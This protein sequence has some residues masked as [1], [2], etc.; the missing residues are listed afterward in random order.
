MGVRELTNGSYHCFENDKEVE[1]WLESGASSSTS[2]LGDNT[3]PG[4]FAY[5]GQSNMTGRRRPLSWTK[6]LRQSTVTAHRNTYSLLDAAALATTAQLDFSDPD[7]APDFTALSFYKIF[8]FPDLGALIV[9]RQSGHILSWRKYFGG[10]TIYYLTVFHESTFRRKD[11]TIHDGLEDGT[12]PFHNI[13]ALGCAMKAH[14]RLYG[15]MQRISQ[16]TLFLAN[17]LYTGMS[18]LRHSN[19]RPLCAIYN[20]TEDG[21][22]YTDPTK[23]GATIAFNILDIHGNHFGYSH[24]EKVANE[25]SIY[26]RAGG[27][28]N[29]GGIAS[30]LEVEPWQFRRAL[31]AGYQCGGEDSLEIISGKLIG[32][33]RASLGAI[34][35][36][37]DVDALV[38]FLSR[39][40]TDRS[41]PD[42]SIIK[43]SK[44]H[45]RA[46]ASIPSHAVDIANHDY[47]IDDMPL[48]IRSS[49]NSTGSH[50]SQKA[51]DQSLS[52]KQYFHHL[53]NSKLEQVP[54]LDIISTAYL[55]KNTTARDGP[56]ISTDEALRRPFRGVQSPRRAKRRSSLKFWRVGKV[57]LD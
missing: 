21:D 29:P 34:S 39:V 42:V 53:G 37:S 10:G 25:K 19:G 51:A 52:L 32:V 41:A 40:F 17:R 3:L 28:C 20:D 27:L 30:Y 45:Q 47:K 9:R 38:L 56:R 50:D 4:L 5:P 24:V 57:Q 35:T 48:A 14:K 33:V 36:M 12:L 6:K 1:E 55:D 44:L 13:I 46:I 7:S 49:T 11:E 2:A 18:A 31:S 54:R 16:H 26:L 8:G 43:P 23:Q 15:S 22:L